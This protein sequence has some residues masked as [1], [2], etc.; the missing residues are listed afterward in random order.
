MTSLRSSLA[1]F[2]GLLCGVGGTALAA[3]D[4]VL[5]TQSSLFATM[6]TTASTQQNA[7][8]NPAN[9]GATLEGSISQVDGGGGFVPLPVMVEAGGCEK[10]LVAYSGTIDLRTAGVAF[11]TSEIVL[12]TA[13]VQIAI[14]TSFNSAQGVIGKSHD[15]DGFQGFNW[16]QAGLPEITVDTKRGVVYLLTSNGS[17]LEYQQV[18]KSDF[19][20]GINGAPGV[21]E[22]TAATLSDH[23]LYTLHEPAGR[24]MSFFGNTGGTPKWQLWKVTNPDGKRLYA[25]H[26]T[27]SITAAAASGAYSS[28]KV[29]SLI[30]EQGASSDERKYVFTYGT[31]GTSKTRLTK[32]EVLPKVG[33][34]FSSTPIAQVDYAYY[35][36]L[37]TIAANGPGTND[38][39]ALGDDGDLKSSTVTIAIDASANDVRTTYYRYY[40]NPAWSLAQPETE[41]HA[42]CVKMVIDPEGYRRASIAATAA[43]TTVDAMTTNDLK[44]YSAGF[45]FYANSGAGPHR[46]AKAFFN[47]EC[48]CGVGPSGLTTFDWE[49]NSSYVNT[50][51]PAPIYDATWYSRIVIGHPD[52][53]YETRYF[54][55]AAQAMGAVTTPADPTITIPTTNFWGTLL[56]RDSQGRISTVYSPAAITSYDHSTG[57][58]TPSTTAG[59]I[60]EYTRDSGATRTNGM[61]TEVAFKQAGGTATTVAK[62]TYATQWS[63][64]ASTIDLT[65]LF[66]TKVEKAVESGVWQTV[67]YEV[68]FWSASG[69]TDYYAIKSFKTKYS[70]VA[71]ANNGENIVA[72]VYTF[73]RKDGRTAFEQSL[74]GVITA[75]LYNSLGL[76]SKYILDAD[77]SASPGYESI[78]EPV[79]YVYT[80]TGP[81]PGPGVPLASSGTELEYTSEFFYD[82]VGRSLLTKLPSG[83]YTGSFYGKLAD[84]RLVTMS[85]PEVTVVSGAATEFIGP[86][87]Y[88]VAN[89]AGRVELSATLATGTIVLSST[90]TSGWITGTNDALDALSTTLRAGDRSKVKGLVTVLYDDAGVKSLESRKY[91]NISTSGTTGAWIG[92][93]SVYDATLTEYDNRGRVSK[94]TDAT[95]TISRTI[96]DA[97][98]RPSSKWT[99]TDDTNWP[100]INTG[101]SPHAAGDMTQVAAFEYDGNNPRGNNYLT[102]FTQFIAGD[103]YGFGDATDRRESLSYYDVRGNVK[104]HIGPTKPYMVMDYDLQGRVIASGGYSSISSPGATSSA[105]TATNR[106]L[107]EKSFYDE[108][109]QNFAQRRYKV[110]QSTGAIMT[111]GLGADDPDGYLET[112]V[113][114]D[115][116]GRIIKEGGARHTKRQYDRLGRAVRQ[117]ELARD[118]DSA[119]SAAKDVIG[120]HVLS[121]N[122]TLYDDDNKTGNVMM[123]A[124]IAR[125][126]AVDSYTITGELDTGYGS[127]ASYAL[128]AAVSG[129]EVLGRIFITSYWYDSQDRPI[130]SLPIGTNGNSPYNRKP[131]GWAG[132]PSRSSTNLLSETK[133]D[134]FGQVFLRVHPRVVGGNPLKTRYLYDAAMRRV[135]EIRNDTGSITLPSTPTSTPIS[136]ADR[137]TDVYTRY[138]YVKGLVS[139]TWVD[140]DGDGTIDTSSPR[141]QVTTC[142]YGV[143]KTGGAFSSQLASNRLLSSVTYPYDAASSTAVDHTITFK[144]NALDQAVGKSDQNGTI[145]EYAYD[146]SGR[147]LSDAVTLPGGSLVDGAVLRIATAYND[148]GLVKTVTQFNATSGG[149]ATDEI[150]CKYDDWGLLSDF[151]QDNDGVVS[152]TG[153]GGGSNDYG[154]RYSYD[155]I[156]TTGV[157][158]STRRDA[159]RREYTRL[160]YAGGTDAAYGANVHGWQ[161]TYLSSSTDTLL[162]SDAGWVTRVY[163]TND[164]GGSSLQLQEYRYGGDGRVLIA[165][166]PPLSMVTRQYLSSGGD[167]YGNYLDQW[168][169]V[170]S[171][172]FKTGAGVVYRGNP[173]YD[174]S[175]NITSVSQYHAPY[176]VVYKSDGLNRLVAATTGVVSADAISGQ[177]YAADDWTTAGTSLTL[178][179]TGNWTSHVRKRYGAFDVTAAGAFDDNNQYASRTETVA[180]TPPV[181]TMYLTQYDK[182]GN[183]VDDDGPATGHTEAAYG[184]RYV[185]D[186]WNRLRKVYDGHGPSGALVEELRYDGFS[187]LIA[188]HADTDLDGDVDGSDVWRHNQYNER[189]Q[190]VATWLGSATK[191]SETYAYHNA[192]RDGFGGSSYVDDLICRDRDKDGDISTVREERLYYVQNIH[193]DVV[194]LLR[195]D[196]LFGGAVVE[197]I[198]YDAYGRPTSFNPADVGRAGG[199]SGPDGSIDNNDDIV[200]YSGS[201][202]QW[203][204]DHGSAGGIGLPDGLKD[205]NDSI[206]F[207]SA[208]LDAN[209]DY[210]GGGYGT[211]SGSGLDNRVGFAGYRW[212]KTLARGGAGSGKPL[213]HVRNR[214]FDSLS[215]K[216]QQRDRLGYVDGMDLYEYGGSSAA[217]LDPMGLSCSSCSNPPPSEPSAPA[218]P[219]TPAAPAEPG[220]P[221]APTTPAGQCP[222][223]GPL[224]FGVCPVFPSDRTNDNPSF[225]QGW[226]SISASVAAMY[227]M[228]EECC[229]VKNTD[230]QKIKKGEIYV[231]CSPDECK[232]EAMAVARAMLEAWVRHYGNKNA[233]P[234]SDAGGVDVGG[235][236]CYD[237]SNIFLTEFNY[238]KPK[239]KCITAK[240]VQLN[241]LGNSRRGGDVHQFL[242]IMFCNKETAPYIKKDNDKHPCIANFDDGYNEDSNPN[243][244][245]FHPG[246]GKL[247]GYVRRGGG[248]E[249]P[250]KRQTPIPPSDTPAVNPVPASPTPP[251]QPPA[252]PAPSR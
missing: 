236:M 120:D 74:D 123:T 42:H 203:Y 234:P 65:R 188:E 189:W 35:T 247:R 216:W 90:P 115:A 140:F 4:P 180:S 37:T 71:A 181:T 206:A 210:G 59:L 32:V 212:D 138:T 250:P 67:E 63:S 99:G 196:S 177:V 184:Y 215:G 232:K 45:F 23:E 44:K 135:A 229:V 165:T 1:T 3:T 26:P 119:Y 175:S 113:W 231:V 191:P 130:A 87:S 70:T 178:S 110:N 122:Q 78:Y 220:T 151:Q 205:N 244:S 179:Q 228:C 166:T 73:L 226:D 242:E 230:E 50:T 76:L 112:S 158:G 133:Y 192:G 57:V 36:T 193:H 109:G 246:P 233:K 173:A 75:R 48:G 146:A 174:E 7:L 6:T 2:A 88:V 153:S 204:T 152:G 186:A 127:P 47:G 241:R 22:K 93:T 222:D 167:P 103:A 15:S 58:L 104:V 161:Y 147:V 124:S 157:S 198:R 183:L 108:R 72:N 199:I 18:S 145:H 224:P 141:D 11:T 25:G 114:R 207:I 213:Y 62:Y 219:A 187:H 129:A 137:D 235:Y 52:G 8:I 16:F 41:G 39:D 85:F 100:P 143:I 101:L 46:V 92:T 239:P 121:E 162:D 49:I 24:E 243:P 68:D 200:F 54:D 170:I 217:A 227:T 27:S 185:Y 159:L 116:A 98:G 17:F 195:A 13:G 131:S 51:S 209:N 61:V 64:L 218:T 38:D 251:S 14:A 214:V 134:E 202:V 19:F 197:R 223:P 5:S 31:G 142:A 69:T 176:G 240:I 43:T 97:P 148:R 21:F 172:E 190:L 225:Q 136:T 139:T 60:T 208:E 40:T 28:G 81:Y 132:I 33:G 56:E 66:L 53:S 83:R 160:R 182:A 96:F 30:Q 171:F 144:Y 252:A 149:S 55:E 95:G 164:D 94:T 105:A 20:R 9:R 168:G 111:T 155:K 211:L 245:M 128:Q 102:K 10:Y 201:G 126:A 150:A 125:H 77:T 163:K 248:A 12:P 249:E 89:L 169:R 91:F 238:I 79:D 154:V 118:D 86:A 29:G 117:F 194:V 84:Q 156:G 107:L 106:V 237:W 80:G 82:A 34:S 221:T